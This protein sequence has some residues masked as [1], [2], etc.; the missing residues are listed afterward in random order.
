ML[1][2]LGQTFIKWTKGRAHLKVKFI[3]NFHILCIRLAEPSL[4]LVKFNMI[5]SCVSVLSSNLA[6][7]DLIQLQCIS[8]LWW[9]GRLS[10]NFIAERSHSGLGCVCVCVCVNDDRF[11]SWWTV[12]FNLLDYKIQISMMF[13]MQNFVCAMHADLV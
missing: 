4:T 6:W 9:I 11:S 2:I 13:S 7:L 5:D 3:C 12:P 1:S 10:V 8:K